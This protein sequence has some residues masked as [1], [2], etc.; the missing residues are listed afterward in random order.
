MTRLRRESTGARFTIL[1]TMAAMLVAGTVSLVLGGSAG[2]A[3]GSASCASAN[4]PGLSGVVTFSGCSD[5]AN[6]G[7]G[8]TAPESAFA[9]NGQS[10]ITWATGH[11]TTTVSMTWRVVSKDEG[12]NVPC[13]S[14]TFESL[15]TGT[16]VGDTG[17]A[18]SIAVGGEVRV[19]MCVD[20]NTLAASNE[21]GTRFKF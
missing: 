20:G 1:S 4:G 7:G 8:G 9:N 16:V 17:L 21:P 2:A 14:S 15:G 6:T 5:R 11:G 18:S 10:T 12:D 3:V 13:P 19:E